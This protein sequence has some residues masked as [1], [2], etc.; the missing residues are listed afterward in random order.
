LWL[1]K[2]NP[3]TPANKLQRDK[4][5]EL[6]NALHTVL[7]AGLKYGG[8]SELAFVTPDGTEGEYQN[9]TLVYGHQGEI[10]DGCK[11]EKIIKYFLGGRGTYVCANCQK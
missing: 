10:C 8:A 1:S 7:K 2:I 11:K 9:H 4:V 6:Y 5:T 3:K